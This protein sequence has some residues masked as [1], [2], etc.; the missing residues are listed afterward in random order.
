MTTNY[1]PHRAAWHTAIRLEPVMMLTHIWRHWQ[2]WPVSAS[3][4]RTVWLLVNIHAQFDTMSRLKPISYNFAFLPTKLTLRWHIQKPGMTHH[5][6][7]LTISCLQ[8]HRVVVVETKSEFGQ[9]NHDH[10]DWFT[11]QLSLHFR[12]KQPQRHSFLNTH[13]ISQPLSHF[14]LINLT[15]THEVFLPTSSDCVTTITRGTTSQL[16][17]QQ[18]IMLM[19]CKGLLA[20]VQDMKGNNIIRVL[21]TA[22]HLSSHVMSSDCLCLYPWTIIKLH[23]CT[24]CHL[25]GLL[26][27]SSTVFFF[28]CR[29]KIFCLNANQGIDVSFLS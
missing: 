15:H 11:S 17:R 26:K 13:N 9:A 22:S 27:N 14:L 5:M 1:S 29:L 23:P 8:A 4:P 7:R 3:T 6:S 12:L 28:N 20:W 18:L 16:I 19:R 24:E 25:S 21:S 2:Y 10:S